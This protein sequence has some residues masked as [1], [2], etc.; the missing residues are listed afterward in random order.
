T[1][2]ARAGVDEEEA[3]L[4]DALRTADAIDRPDAL[5]VQLG[6]PG[7]LPLGVVL[8][9]VVGD[10]T[11]D[12]R[13]EGLAPALLVFVEVGVA[14]EHPAG[15]AEIGLP[16]LYVLIADLANK[17][18][19]GVLRQRPEVVGDDFLQLVRRL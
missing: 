11:R 12:E 16:D 4:G 5:T 18:H 8:L 7:G 15:I 2:A 10:H 14:L 9:E 1:V 17:Q 3:E 6:D 19:L 13:G